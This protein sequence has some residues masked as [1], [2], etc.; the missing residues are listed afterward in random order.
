MTDP[1]VQDLLRAPDVIAETGATYRQLD[2]WTRSG[3]IQPADAEPTNG[4]TRKPAR[5]VT[6]PGSGRARLWH[7]DE[8]EV[9]AVKVAAADGPVQLGP[10]VTITTA[11]E[12][13]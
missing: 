1:T 3:Y 11:W 9:M 7:P 13:R 4:T 6:S 12:A 5:D 2:Y 8:V 10:G